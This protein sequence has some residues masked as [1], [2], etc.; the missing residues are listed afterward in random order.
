MHPHWIISQ[1][2]LTL[3]FSMSSNLDLFLMK[4]LSTL[5]DRMAWIQGLT[6][7]IYSWLKIYPVLFLSR[8]L[9]NSWALTLQWS[10]CWCNTSWWD[11]T[12]FCC[13]WW[14]GWYC[15]SFA[16]PPCRRKCHSHLFFFWTFML[17]GMVRSTIKFF[18]IL[19]SV[20]PY[21]STLSYLSFFLMWLALS[22]C[23]C[24]SYSF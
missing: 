7:K 21:P 1:D 3:Y 14:A 20:F 2:I 5:L 19:I 13:P 8:K 22:C 24:C 18:Y 10:L 15:E 4:F 6:T 11:G 16:R 23:T 17:F 9:W 12:A